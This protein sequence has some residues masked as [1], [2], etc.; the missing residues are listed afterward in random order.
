MDVRGPVMALTPGQDF[1]PC[2]GHQHVR[3]SYAAS[4]AD[5]QKGLDRLTRFVKALV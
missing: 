4:K 5:L 1:G 2:G 3:L